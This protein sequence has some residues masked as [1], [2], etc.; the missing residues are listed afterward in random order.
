MESRKTFIG[1]NLN[2][3][4]QDINQL[5]QEMQE[6]IERGENESASSLLTS[7]ISLQFLE[8]MNNYYR[9]TGKKAKVILKA[10]TEEEFSEIL[11]E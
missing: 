2:E 4:E 5:K 3:L 9:R 1:Q 8:F 10:L 6:I 11:G 7:S